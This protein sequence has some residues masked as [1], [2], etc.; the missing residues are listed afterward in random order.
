MEENN[1]WNNMSRAAP[2]RAKRGDSARSNY[3]RNRPSRVNPVNAARS[4][5]YIDDITFN[6]M[7]TSGMM[8]VLAPVHFTQFRVPVRQTSEPNQNDVPGA[9]QIDY[10]LGWI[11]KNL[12]LSSIS[13][14]EKGKAGPS[15]FKST[16]KELLAE[17]LKDEGPPKKDSR[18][19]LPKLNVEE[20]DKADENVRTKKKE[21]VMQWF[22]KVVESELSK[23][24]NP[25]SSDFPGKFKSN[26]GKI[27]SKIDV[28][29]KESTKG[30]D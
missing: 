23:R 17:L 26:A 10:R 29:K 30:I 3:H 28:T 8:G 20:S 16:D 9:Q 2:S 1:N 21:T 13:N 15:K 6:A 18:F 7:I 19:L 12:N 4:Q 14:N 27:S 24:K 5:A 11:P 25:I 22:D